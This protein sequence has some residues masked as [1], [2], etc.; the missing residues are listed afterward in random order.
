MKETADSIKK[1]LL[2]EGIYNSEDELTWLTD[3][4]IAER[5]K[6]SIER[7]PLELD[8][9]E[10]NVVLNFIDY[11]NHFYTTNNGSVWHWDSGDN[12]TGGNLA[13]GRKH[14]WKYTRRV[15]DSYVRAGNCREGYPYYKLDIYH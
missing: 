10:A 6:S 4:F 5:E 9:K 2:K 13:C 1:N 15:G 12:V 8:A 3:E 14:S 11:G 7:K